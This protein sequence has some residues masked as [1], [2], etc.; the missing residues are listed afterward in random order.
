MFSA[1]L[2]YNYKEGF[3]KQQH[4]QIC[5]RAK[6]FGGGASYMNSNLV[7]LMA[8]GGKLAVEST[9]LDRLPKEGLKFGIDCIA[10]ILKQAMNQP[11]GSPAANLLLGD[12]SEI[13]DAARK[14][15]LDRVTLFPCPINDDLCLC[16]KM[17]GGD[18]AAFSR[19][20]G[21][22]LWDPSEF[23]AS[24][25]EQEKWIEQYGVIL[26]QKAP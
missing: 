13:K 5:E 22:A 18:H 20:T 23:A 19:S 26:Y 10:D 11:E 16:I 24:K 12:I 8:F 15:G 9:D 6:D 14:H 4:I 21:I 2:L 3:C 25:T 17:E 1:M 7:N